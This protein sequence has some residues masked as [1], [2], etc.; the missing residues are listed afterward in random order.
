MFP[1]VLLLTPALPQPGVSGG[2]R[3]TL[4]LLQA[5]LEQGARVD[6]ACFVHGW[7]ER[8]AAGAIA[9]LER[10]GV[11]VIAIPLPA[12]GARE[13]GLPE[14]HQPFPSPAF[15]RALEAWS[16]NARADVA[17]FDHESMLLHRAAAQAP[18]QWLHVHESNVLARW[19]AAKLDSGRKWHHRAEALR[20]GAFLFERTAGLSGAICLTRE[21]RQSLTPFLRTRR[22]PVAP[23]D[24]GVDDPRPREEI[25]PPSIIWIGNL[26]H[27]PNREG[28]TWFGEAVWPII[29]AEAPEAVLE[30]FC[31]VLTENW[32]KLLPDHPAIRWR[33]NEPDTDAILRSGRISIAPAR[34]GAGMR[35]KV[36]ES[37]GRGTPVVSTPAGLAGLPARAPGC[38]GASGAGEFAQ[39]C[40]ALLKD[41]ERWR[42]ASRGAA[43]T[44]RNYLPN[45]IRA[46]LARWI[47]G[48]AK[49]RMWK[50]A[51]RVEEAP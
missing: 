42:D 44:A 14:I 1:H 29:Q 35:S 13:P 8:A 16:K 51:R 18:V 2:A 32:K 27:E 22:T 17:V 43:E 5:L 28:L 11:G 49:A 23:L 9:A 34:L 38:S 48:E 15:T 3:R 21:D 19:R 20:H 24:C 6:V 41:G 25:P 47:T 31:P 4:A 36:I 40:I 26:D 7:Q 33:I 50:P 45:T 37:L 46:E 30:A 12:S 10:T 39:A